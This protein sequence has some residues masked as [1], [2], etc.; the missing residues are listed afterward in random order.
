MTQP[1]IQEDTKG[2]HEIMIQAKLNINGTSIFQCDDKNDSDAEAEIMHV[3]SKRINENIIAESKITRMKDRDSISQVIDS[4]IVIGKYKRLEQFDLKTNCKN[5]IE[6]VLSGSCNDIETKIEYILNDFTDSMK[7]RMREEDKYVLAI[8]HCDYL[9]LCHSRGRESTITPG[10]KVVKRMLDRDNVDRFIYF[11]RDGR[12]IGV[13]YYEHYPSESF[14]AWLGIPE[15]EAF[16]YM[17]GRNRIYTVVEG[18]KCAM[19]LSDEEIENLI[20]N[21]RSDLIIENGL[22]RFPNPINSL[23][24]E[25]IRVRKKSYKNMDDFL[26]GYFARRY[27]LAFYCQKYKDLINSLEPIMMQF[28][29]YMDQVVKIESNIEKTYIFKRNATMYIL[30]ASK[31]T[32]G[33]TI[34]LQKSFFT[35]IYTKFLNNNTVRIFHAG[36]ELYP[37]NDCIFRIGSME[38]FNRL[39][40]NQLILELNAM[41]NATSLRDN[42]LERALCYGIFYILNAK[43]KNTP[44]SLFLE[45]MLKQLGKEIKSSEK[46]IDN[47]SDRIEFKSRDF[48]VG[49]ND[50]IGRKISQDIM[51]KLVRS[52]FKIYI[53]GINEDT[54]EIEPLTNNNF[55][56]DRLTALERGISRELNKDLEVSIVKVPIGNK[57][58]LELIVRSKCA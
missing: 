2:K 56:S 42:I 3:Y 57:C 4:L 43:N 39:E 18:I 45:K 50:E 54:L 47:E 23:Q 33:G 36:M 34:Q 11:K 27:N 40:L 13:Y 26:Q 19:E 6:E 1:K 55:P 15:K 48:V 30:F 51:K 16:Y 58:L 31:L 32:S 29:D 9:I 7:T 52:S 10:W 49:N 12:S 37:S 44:I 41:Y 35:E 8:I 25:Q 17:G 14:I 53:F 20:L 38:F 24:V 46:I 21:K 28:I 22:I 5:W